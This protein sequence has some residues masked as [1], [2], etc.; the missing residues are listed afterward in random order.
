M[1]IFKER[2]EWFDVPNDPDGTRIKI[3][4][5][6]EGKQQELIAK[7][8]KLSFVFI[9][10]KQENH[11]VPDEIMIR[12][13]G[14]DARIVDWE[15]VYGPNGKPLECNTAN[16]IQIACEKGFSDILKDMIDKL[17]KAVDKEREL[18]EKNLPTSQ[19][20]CPVLTGNPVKSADSH[21][22]SQGGT[23]KNKR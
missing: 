15:N 10:N 20:G 23:Q 22:G 3:R 16:K 11:M 1:R 13:E 14:V 19:G 18:E 17:D 6:N 4:Y 5:L 9:D 7:C 21:S 12:N 2:E 8:R